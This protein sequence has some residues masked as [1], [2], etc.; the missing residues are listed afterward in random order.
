[1]K[2][3]IAPDSFKGSV[4]AVRAAAAISSGLRRAQPQVECVEMP[5][6][7]GGEG[8][9]DALADPLGL[10]RISVGVRGP[11][12]Q[13]ISA[14]FGWSETLRLAVIEVAEA[15]GVHLVA[16]K[17][18]DVLRADSYGVGQLMEVA[19][20][21]GARRIL[22]GLGG[23]LTNDGGAGLLTALGAR[24][25]DQRGDDVDG[26]PLGLQRA[27]ALDATTL[28]TW[29]DIELTVAS[30]VD[31]PLTGPRGASAVFGPQKGASPADLM[32][33]DSALSRWGR[34][35]QQSYLDP[36]NCPA[37]LAERPGA[38]AAGGIGVSLLF[39]GARV[40]PGIDIVLEALQF[41]RRLAGADWVVTGEG[42][43]DGQT[44]SG[45]GPW[46]VC[47]A[48][49]SA[50]VGTIALCGRIGDGASS[51]IGPSGFV[52]IIG[53][54]PEGQ[55]EGEALT[56]AVPNL[57][58]AAYRVGSALREGPNWQGGGSR[59][60]EAIAPWPW[61]SDPAA[62]RPPSPA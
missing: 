48:A 21:R 4:D 9:L 20:R 60:R 36:A 22:I 49:H 18:R 38:G 13:D 40:R 26:N 32:I 27:I 35:L 53:I 15:I 54:T 61:C 39:L 25:L 46:G 43:I 2:I 28:S 12:G 17:G 14:D 51:L 33:L 58:A 1:M 42:C 45:K 16:G 19:R 30:D 10:Q 31:N 3:V 59:G 34:I 52:T 7:D 50:G 44:A 56:Q 37:P 11:L 8:L 47:Q 29:H 5:I 6:A 41:P 62:L 23:S 55:A 24:V 57:E